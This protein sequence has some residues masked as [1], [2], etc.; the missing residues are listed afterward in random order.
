MKTDP[1]MIRK[2]PIPLVVWIRLLVAAIKLEALSTNPERSSAIPFSVM[3]RM[4]LLTALVS[5]PME[6]ITKMET[7]VAKVIKPLRTRP[8]A[9]DTSTRAHSKMVID[10]L[11]TPFY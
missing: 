11:N 10:I 4:D 9:L 5:L 1:L 8:A 3:C 7:P 6:R 2:T